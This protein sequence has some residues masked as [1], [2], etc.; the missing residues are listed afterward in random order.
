MGEG[1]VTKCTAVMRVI[2][3]V[4]TRNDRNHSC[5]DKFYEQLMVIQN[6]YGETNHNFGLRTLKALQI[7]H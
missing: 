4:T 5:Q 6:F 7:N 1:T 3:C 2:Q